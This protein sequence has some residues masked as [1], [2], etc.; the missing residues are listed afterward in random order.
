MQ[1]F[2]MIDRPHNESTPKRVVLW[3]V[4]DGSIPIDTFAVFPVVRSVDLAIL[5][6]RTEFGLHSVENG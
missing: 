5:A 2:R 1:T 3:R 4:M 6:P